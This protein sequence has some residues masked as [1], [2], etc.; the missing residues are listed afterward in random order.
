MDGNGESIPLGP[1]RKRYISSNA[2]S[3]GTFL[4]TQK[5]L[6]SQTRQKNRRALSMA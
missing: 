5:A 6:V 4:H 3:C 2:V 1:E